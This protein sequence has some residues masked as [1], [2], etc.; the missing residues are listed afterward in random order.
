V[1]G[2]DGKVLRVE[3]VSGPP[4]LVEAAVSAVRQWR[5][6]PSLSDGHR[7]QIQ[8]DITLVFRLPN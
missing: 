3:P 2:D 4:L 5:Y 6:G 7:V 1:I 8:E